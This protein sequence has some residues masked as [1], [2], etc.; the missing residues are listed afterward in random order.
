MIFDHAQKGQISK[1]NSHR[2]AHMAKRKA[3]F[4]INVGTP[5][6]VPYAAEVPFEL[7]IGLARGTDVSISR[8]SQNGEDQKK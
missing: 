3:I 2:P 8:G 5:M 1:I 7:I 6:V 4:T